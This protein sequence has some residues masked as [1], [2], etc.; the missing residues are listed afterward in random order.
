MIELRVWCLCA[1]GLAPTLSAAAQTAQDPLEP[2]VVYAEADAGAGRTALARARAEVV[3]RLA[4]FG[5]PAAERAT[6]VHAAVPAGA[7]PAPSPE[8]TLAPLMQAAETDLARGAIDLGRARLDLL[9]R[10]APPSSPIALRASELLRTGA[11]PA[12]PAATTTAVVLPALA[13]N[14]GPTHAPPPRS[15]PVE[16]VDPDRRSAG[17]L[18]EL[19]AWTSS[20]GGFTGAYTLSLFGVEDAN[21]YGF[22]IP[23]GGALGALSVFALDE[24]DSLPLGVPTAISTGLLIGLGEGLLG[25]GAFGLDLQ[26]HNQ[27]LGIVW[28]STIAGAGIGAALGYG[29]RPSRGQTRL[30]L[31]GGLWGLWGVGVGLLAAETSDA[32]TILQWLFAAYNTG[33]VGAAILAAVTDMSEGRVWL[34][35]AGLAAGAAAGATIPA[36]VAAGDAEG[37]TNVQ[38]LAISMGVGSMIGFGL[39]LYLTRDMAA[40]STVPASPVQAYATPIEG[41]FM[42]GAQGVL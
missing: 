38:V 13:Y 3:V 12:P 31:S 5:S 36:L 10:A 15:A 26:H 9:V 28:V 34:L 35:H 42:A 4:P 19:Y 7:G 25:Y 24:S 23:I 33:I 39:S 6:R 18:V 20:F 2:L 8:E 27:P 29:L 41:G 40:G 11:V 21:Y 22:G 14:A 16:P 37:E 32:E 30:V 17:E 1:C